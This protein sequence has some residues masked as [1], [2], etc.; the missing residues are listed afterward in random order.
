MLSL[1][2]RSVTCPCFTAEKWLREWRAKQ[3]E[4]AGPCVCVSDSN[5]NVLV[6]ICSDGGCALM[7]KFPD[8]A[9][10]SGA[11]CVCQCRTEPN[12]GQKAQ[13]APT[14]PER[15]QRQ[16]PKSFIS[17]VETRRK[18]SEKKTDKNV[19]D[20][21]VFSS[22]SGRRKSCSNRRQKNQ[23]EAMKTLLGRRDTLLIGVAL[24][25]CPGNGRW[26]RSWCCF[27]SCSSKFSIF[28]FYV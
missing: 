18:S 13:K 14:A 3:R 8:S 2:L 4:S 6:F 1:D 28:S 17:T 22:V 15:K 5:L 25:F 19:I 9:N 23:S 11:V 10:R 16:T 26:W 24:F 20:V 21:I 7:K 12:A 27:A